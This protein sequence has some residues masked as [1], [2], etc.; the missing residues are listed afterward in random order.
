MDRADLLMADREPTPQEGRDRIRLIQ[1]DHPS[2]SPTLAR[3]RNRSLT[4][5][6]PSADRALDVLP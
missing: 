2:P 4:S 3:L 6:G 1:R 5:S